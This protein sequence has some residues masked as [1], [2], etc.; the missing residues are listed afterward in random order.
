METGKLFFGLK[1]SNL[2][3]LNSDDALTLNQ[4]THIAA[5]YDGLEMRV[6]ID[7]NV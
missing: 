7:G 5:T 1:G 3:Y 6:Y 2:H 4:W